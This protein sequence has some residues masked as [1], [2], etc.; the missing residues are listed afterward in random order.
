MSQAVIKEGEKVFL[1]SSEKFLFVEVFRNNM[2]LAVTWAT[3]NEEKPFSVKF[4]QYERTYVP[5][6]KI[7]NDDIFNGIAI[8]IQEYINLSHIEKEFDGQDTIPIVF[9]FSDFSE[10]KSQFE[11]ISTRIGPISTFKSGIVGKNYC[12]EFE[13]AMQLIISKKKIEYTTHMPLNSGNFLSF[14]CFKTFKEDQRPHANFDFLE[15]LGVQE[16]VYC[17][18]V[19]QQNLSSAKLERIYP[20]SVLKGEGFK[21][22]IIS[23]SF[24]QIGKCNGFERN[25]IF[26]FLT[27]FERLNFD[28]NPT[29]GNDIFSQIASP[30]RQAIHLQNYIRNHPLYLINPKLEEEPVVNMERFDYFLRDKYKDHCSILHPYTFKL[31]G[32][33]INRFAKFVMK[34]CLSFSAL[35]LLATIERKYYDQIEPKYKSC[36][37]PKVL[38]SIRDDDKGISNG[39]ETS[40]IEYLDEGARIFWKQRRNDLESPKFEIISDFNSCMS[41]NHILTEYLR[42][43]VPKDYWAKNQTKEDKDELAERR[44][45][46]MKA[47]K[48]YREE[49]EEEENEIK[50]MIHNLAGMDVFNDI[51]LTSTCDKGDLKSIIEKSCGFEDIGEIESI[52][53]FH[54]PKEAQIKPENQK[55]IDTEIVRNSPIVAESTIPGEEKSENKKSENKNTPKLI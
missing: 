3:G 26:K 28:T 17:P 44:V 20:D 40:I 13:K 15:G 30:L 51:N 43:L 39:F 21:S 45:S 42:T 8:G 19:K 54:T 10:G 12:K 5:S 37:T 35:A 25:V 6:K 1:R 38:I 36:T 16:F 32:A 9:C 29:I 33:D 22:I 27:R 14:Y 34:R 23:N 52:Q 18:K 4:F 24:H 46:Y 53:V 11:K 49:R 47:L 7:N 55:K 2:Y 48:V 41:G 50:H 31:I